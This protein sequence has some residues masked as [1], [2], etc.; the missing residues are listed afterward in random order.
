MKLREFL[1]SKKVLATL[2]VV[3]AVV[4]FM[5]FFVLSNAIGGDATAKKAAE[6]D[7]AI[8]KANKGTTTEAAK[9]TKTPIMRPQFRV[10]QNY[11]LIDP[12]Q[13]MCLM[14]EEMDK[15]FNQAF[16]RFQ[17]S[18]GFTV[19][20]PN[21]MI[22][23]PRIDLKDAGKNYI[24]KM[25]VPGVQKDDIKITLRNRLLTISGKR[26][27]EVKE[28]TDK[29]VT[30]ERRLGEFARTFS[31]PGPIDENKL[32][33]VCQDGVLTVTL[34][35]TNKEKEEIEIKVEGQ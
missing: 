30:M 35:K 12:F 23:S 25:D 16:N 20:S 26:K 7:A 15:L 24:V 13:E 2:T 1:N 9:E 5:Q 17:S 4:A 18:P 22:F 31:L 11:S 32:K 33:A 27:E 19:V 28:K 29:M 10:N 34:P 14:Q 3:L 8:Q 21:Q 6:K